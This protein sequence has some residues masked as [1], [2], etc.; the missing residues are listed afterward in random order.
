MNPKTLLLAVLCTSAL[1]SLPREADAFHFNTQFADHPFQRIVGAGGRYYTGSPRNEGM[2][3]THCHVDA[4]RFPARVSLNVVA[5]I[6]NS[7]SLS[8]STLFTAGY[9]P[10]AT[11]KIT[12]TM[13][14]EHRG[15]CTTGGAYQGPASSEGWKLSCPG[16]QCNGPGSPGNRDQFTAEVMSDGGTYATAS[17]N[18]AGRLRP[19]SELGAAQPGQCRVGPSFCNGGQFADF[20]PAANMGGPTTAMFMNWRL[21]DPNDTQSGPFGRWSCLT[22]CDAIVSNNGFYNWTE[23]QGSTNPFERSFAFFWTAPPSPPAAAAGRI[24][25]YMAA[26]DGDGFNDTMDDDVATVRVAVCPAG[27]ST[28]DPN[29]G[30]GWGL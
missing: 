2:D 12:V 20:P 18:A 5:E 23:G 27:A 9:Q 19:D 14:D 25:F 3:C 6:V 26:V 7:G 1:S 17:G 8:P 10:N 28:C 15:M 4:Q 22:D 21:T 11:Y 13:I 29:V 24:R 16:S 30:P